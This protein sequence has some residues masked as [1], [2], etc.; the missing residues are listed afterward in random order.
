MPI[1]N[2]LNGDQHASHSSDFQ[3]YMLV[4]I[5]ATSYRN[6]LQMVVEIFMALKQVPTD[7]DFP[8]AV[9]DEGRFAPSVASNTECLIF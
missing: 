3:E 5:G 2:V 8:T 6:G 9:G 1:C 7:R 4:P